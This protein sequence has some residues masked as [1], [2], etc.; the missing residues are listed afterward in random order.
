MRTADDGRDLITRSLDAGAA[1]VLVPAIDNLEQ[2]K[3]VVAAS[4]YVPVGR[5]GVHLFRGHTRYRPKTPRQFLQ[6]ANRDVL[7]LIQIELRGAAEIVDE[8]AA[9]P[10]VDGLYIGPADLS[11]DLGVPGEPDSP[12]VQNVIR[13]AAA[14][15]RKHGKIMCSHL[16][17]EI[18][19][20]R[21]LQSMGVQMFGYDCDLGIFAK[22]ADR[23]SAQFAAELGLQRKI[24]GFS[25]TE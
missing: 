17:R 23:A 9:M 20:A 19:S 1:G 7:T 4:K 11:V 16:L 22:A 12:L 13:R 18:N 2:V 15:C 21:A 3:R 24:E 6:E 14:A 5:R 10:G 8:I 25:H